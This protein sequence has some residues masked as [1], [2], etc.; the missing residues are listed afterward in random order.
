MNSLSAS[1]R[2]SEIIAFSRKNAEEEVEQL[3]L[4]DL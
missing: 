2:L 4:L 3:L 1:D